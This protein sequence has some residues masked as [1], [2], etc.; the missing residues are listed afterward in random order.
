MPTSKQIQQYAK[1]PKLF[2][3]DL[4]VDVNGSVCNF[5]DVMD[6]WQREDFNAM[7]DAMRYCSGQT[8]DKP[9]AMYHYRGRARGHSKTTDLAVIV[10]WVMLFATRQL[11]G[12]AYAEDRD[13][14]KLLKNSIEQL[15]RLNPWLAEVLEVQASA[16]V[17]IKENLPGAGSTLSIE[18]SNVAS[19]YGILPDFIIA[20]ELCHWE[21]DKGQELWTSILSSAAK[22]DRCLLCA[23]SNAG[24][25]TDWQWDIVCAMQDDPAWNYV[26]LEGVKASWLNDKRL[27]SQRKM[28]PEVAY[29]RLWENQWSSGGGDA[30]LPE[31]I[32]AAF[33]A[34]LLPMT[35]N[36]PGYSFVAGVDLSKV[37]D[38]TAIVV[39]GVPDDGKVGRIR[40]ANHWTYKPTHDNPTLHLEVVQKL[41][42]LDE[43]YALRY[44]GFDSYES[45]YP[46][47]ALEA[48][49]GKWR[50][51]QYHYRQQP[52]AREIPPSPSNQRL[53][54]LHTLEAFNDR[55]LDLYPCEPLKTDL[56]K[57]RA[58]EK[59]YGVKLECKRDK[60]GHGDTY[61]AFAVALLLATEVAAEPP[62]MMD[63]LL[64]G[65]G[66]NYASQFAQRVKE[67]EA[68]QRW[69]AEPEPNYYPGGQL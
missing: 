52:F 29:R 21:H 51:S 49:G 6:P 2:R 55:R 17:H 44:V 32:E 23:I 22:R 25:M 59:S 36:E 54:T 9:E 3:R 15:L 35:G 14:A 16:V 42:E 53:F 4:R 8:Q 60:D 63:D 65:D 13:Q 47:Q 40:L 64:S 24:W 61:S 12:Y 31:A 18:A 39:L 38:H 30:L 45:S 69:L 46:I 19:S 58:E 34:E 11:R 67:Y 20:D 41:L 66:A 48:D 27:E 26:H 10:I 43:T 50:R 1:H 37:R 56:Y 7:D 57:L 68:E 33:K 62:L 5:G 28:M